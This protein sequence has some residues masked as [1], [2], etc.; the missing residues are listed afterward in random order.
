MHICKVIGKNIFSWE[1]LLIEFEDKHAY[2]FKGMNGVGKSSIL[3]IVKWVFFKKSNKKN[4]VQYGKQDGFGIVV[5]EDNKSLYNIARSTKN[6]TQVTINEE[7]VEQEH[8]EELIGCTYSTFMSAIMCDQKKASAFINEETGTGKARIFGEM[9]GAGILDQIRDKIQKHKNTAEMEYNSLKGTVDALKDRLD[10]VTL[11]LGEYSPK[12][13]LSIL[14]CEMEKLGE[15]KK[16]LEQ[17]KIECD[18]KLEINNEWIKYAELV[19]NY[20]SVE[21]DIIKRKNALIKFEHNIADQSKLIA[22]IIKL[23]GKIKEIIDKV[24]EFRISIHNKNKIIQDGEKITKSGGKCPTCGQMVTEPEIIQSH[25]KIIQTEKNSVKDLQIQLT[26]HMNAQA[27]FNINLEKA[28]DKLSEQKVLIDKINNLKSDISEKEAILKQYDLSKPSQPRP[29][30]NLFQD[31]VNSLTD[32]ILNKTSIIERKKNAIKNYAEAKRS[33][34]NLKTS[35]TKSEYKL[36]MFKWLFDNIP[37]MK[38]RFIDNSK[39]VV[40][41][42]INE[43]LTKMGLPFIVKIDTQRDLVS[44][45]KVKDEFTFKVVNTQFKEEAN[46]KDISGGEETC[47]LLATQFAI[48]TVSNN[49]LGFEIYDEIY[50][51]LDDKNISAIIETLQD[52]AL[53]KQV[54]SISHKDEISNAF[55]DVIEIVKVDG[56]SQLKG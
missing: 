26:E 55:D 8:L 53:N 51:S 46:K 14:K 7:P 24:V 41:N 16:E 30:I 35:I 43:N 21:S 5:L 27:T 34:D 15:Q 52:R 28:E 3:E 20:E 2:S 23:R 25:L 22:E 40:E 54:F 45:D 4:I 10:N 13:Y 12:E 11:E 56:V 17:A 9:I 39:C 49:H 38:L 19:R 48:N 42:I 32:S 50:G 44:S 36:F 29:N 37:I 33:L 6:P 31:K 47:I 1:E 18:K